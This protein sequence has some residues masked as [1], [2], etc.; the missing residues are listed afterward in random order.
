MPLE[1][2]H[3]RR[4]DLLGSPVVFAPQLI[5]EV[6]YEQRNVFGTLAERRHVDRNDRKAEV[7][8]LAEVALLDFGLEVLVR[9]RDHAHIHVDRLRRA[10]AFDLA[11]LK[12]AQRLGLRL[13]THV[14]HFVEEDRAAVCLLEFPNLP[15]R[16]AGKRALLVA[17]QLRLDELLGNRR[18]ID[19]HEALAAAGAQAV[20]RPGDELLAN[21]A[22]PL[23]Q[24]S[25]M[26]GSGLANGLFHFPERRAGADHLVLRVDFLPQRAIRRLRA[27]SRQLFLDPLE[28]DRFGERLLDETRRAL[29]AR[30]ERVLRRAV[31]RD[32]HD[33]NGRV[34]GLDA[35]EHF[36]PVHARHLDVEEHQIRWIPLDQR[37]PFLAGCSPNELVALIFERPPH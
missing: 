20:N 8:I 37:K 27:M 36:E 7:Q 4:R 24:D 28:Q 18:A 31:P 29:V 33:R 12:H 35:L 11:F 22:F 17:E 19:L 26:R 25:R 21:T 15:L 30:F 32:H 3:G 14:R 9:R 5:D 2:V 1:H 23:Q 13:Q 16:G 10:Q 34:G 6:L